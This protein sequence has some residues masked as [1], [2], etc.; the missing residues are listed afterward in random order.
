MLRYTNKLDT[1][2]IVTTFLNHSQITDPINIFFSTPLCVKITGKL[3]PLP[4]AQAHG[5]VLGPMEVWKLVEVCWEA[6]TQTGGHLI[7]R[8]GEMEM[9]WYWKPEDLPHLREVANCGVC[10]SSFL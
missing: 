7:F 10:M 2:N 5:L 4:K 9:S 1:P 6:G 8:C 3:F